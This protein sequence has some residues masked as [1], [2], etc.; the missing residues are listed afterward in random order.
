MT[1]YEFLMLDDAMQYQTTWELGVPI[2]NILY[3]NIHYILYAINDFYVEVHY[4]APDNKIIGKLPFKSGEALD[5]YLI[6]FPP[7]SAL[8]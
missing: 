3:K 8:Y 5:K 7:G 1:L 4:N 6:K 2:D